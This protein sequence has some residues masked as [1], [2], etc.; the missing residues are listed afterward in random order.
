MIAYIALKRLSFILFCMLIWIPCLS[1]ADGERVKITTLQHSTTKQIP[2]SVGFKL[3]YLPNNSYS[4]EANNRS[5]FLDLN[6][7]EAG[8]YTRLD[9][10]SYEDIY[11]P[12]VLSGI[13]FKQC[14]FDDY[15]SVTDM[16]YSMQSSYISVGSDIGLNI[17]DY[18]ACSVGFHLDFL[19]GF[20]SDAHM[21]ELIGLNQDCL[22]G[23]IPQLS[24]GFT[25]GMI[26]LQF[27][28]PLNSGLINLDRYAYYNRTRLTYERYHYNTFAI[29]IRLFGSSNKR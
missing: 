4:Y 10:K 3:S 23:V 12:Y 19:T 22:N 1:A 18:I 11:A 25:F 27:R 14:Y 7:W 2:Y 29:R 26:E 17:E 5:I 20:K 24:I 28:V 16:A 15:D 21:Y 13:S 6:G 9:L 8:A